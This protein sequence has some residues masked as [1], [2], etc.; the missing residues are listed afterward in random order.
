MLIDTLK[1]NFDNAYNFNSAFDPQNEFPF[2][3][4]VDIDTKDKKLS[5]QFIQIP[6]DATYPISSSKIYTLDSLNGDP[7]EF[8]IDPEN[9]EVINYRPKTVTGFR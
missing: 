8:K 9:D 7:V 6:K 4:K 1:I 5:R 2:Q 3:F